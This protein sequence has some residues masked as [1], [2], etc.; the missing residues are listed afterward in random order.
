MTGNRGLVDKTYK[1]KKRPCRLL[2]TST[3][4]RDS[5]LRFGSGM[6]GNLV[7]GKIKTYKAK[8]KT[9]LVTSYFYLRTSFHLQHL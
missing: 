4:L 6:T 8:K 2:R 7:A 3:F 5:S 1:V 9:L